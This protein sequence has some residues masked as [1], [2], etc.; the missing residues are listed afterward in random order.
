MPAVVTH[1]SSLPT[2]GSALPVLTEMKSHPPNAVTRAPSSWRYEQ[3]AL[4]APF[5][6]SVGP[7]DASIPWRGSRHDAGDAS[8]TRFVVLGCSSDLRWLVG[9]FI[10]WVSAPGHASGHASLLLSLSPSPKHT[11]PPTRLLDETL[12]IEVK[13]PPPPPSLLLPTE[14]GLQEAFLPGAAD[15]GFSRCCFG[16]GLSMALE[17]AS[18]CPWELK[19]L[20]LITDPSLEFELSATNFIDLGIKCAVV[21]LTQEMPNWT[22][23]PTF[24][25]L[26]NLRH[27]ADWSG[28][29]RGSDRVILDTRINWWYSRWRMDVLQTIVGY[30]SVDRSS[31]SGI[32]CLGDVQWCDEAGFQQFMMA[33]MD[34]GPSQ[35]ERIEVPLWSDQLG[36]E[37]GWT[38]DDPRTACTTPIIMLPPAGSVTMPAGG[39]FNMQDMDGGVAA[40]AGCFYPNEYDGDT[41]GSMYRVGGCCYCGM[42]VECDEVFSFCGGM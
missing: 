7:L 23:S 19:V 32:W 28:F 36:L 6:P 5:S 1:Q 39:W 25:L 27:S 29:L 34:L 22:N 10:G 31:I 13:L 17:C 40:V 26:H 38:S 33:S 12:R 30:N 15:P 24:Y 11:R 8:P 42:N 3:Q 41:H 4:L 21:K 14:D 20:L 37:N 2:F 16:V 18:Q 35:V 9:W